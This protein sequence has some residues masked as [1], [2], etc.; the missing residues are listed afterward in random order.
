MTDQYKKAIRTTIKRIRTNTSVHFRLI[1]SNQICNKIRA[2]E[3]YR[4]A[5]HLALYFAVNGEVDLTLLWKTAPLHGKFCY[6]PVINE[7]DATLSFLPATPATAFKNNRFGI[8]EPDVSM[9]QAISLEQLDLVLL[10]LVAFDIH[11]VRLGMG[12]GYYDRTFANIN[13]TKLLGVAYQFQ[14]ID[15]INPEPWDVALDAVVTESAIYRR[16]PL[17]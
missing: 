16:N 13:N 15:F 7:N 2:L 4:K 12:A 1:T 11:C 6:F 8:A 17:K 10:P 3:T 9:D 14:R 5:K